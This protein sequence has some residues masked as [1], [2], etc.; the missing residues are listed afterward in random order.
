MSFAQRNATNETSADL[1]AEIGRLIRDKLGVDAGSPDEDLIASGV[2]DSLT[3]V[4]LLLEIEE[5]L[6]IT[7]PLGDVEIDEVRSIASLARLVTRHGQACAGM[8]GRSSGGWP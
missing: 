6:G 7:I 8:A 1:E 2:L 4:Q 5:H 3:L